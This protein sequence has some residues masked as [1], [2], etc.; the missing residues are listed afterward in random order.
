[1]M[2][3]Y[4]LLI[5]I[6]AFNCCL[7]NINNAL[8]NPPLA[9][10]SAQNPESLNKNLTCEE[11]CAISKA[12]SGT[13]RRQPG[14]YHQHNN[15]EE[16]PQ[17]LVI[18]EQI[19]RGTRQP[20]NEWLHQSSRH[21]TLANEDY[22]RQSSIIFGLT[23]IANEDYLSPACFRNLK[24]LGKAVLRKD[25]WAMK[26]LDSSGSKN[27]GFLWGQNYWLGSQDGCEA[28]Q[29]PVYITL[30]DQYERA[31]KKGLI[32]D[33]AP[34]EMDYRVVYIRHDS[35]WQVEIKFMTE[36]IIHVGL[37]LPKSCSN[38][39]VYNLT[40][41]YMDWGYFE[42]ANVY[43][44]NP[45]V[46]H[47]KDLRLRDDFFDK[48]SFKIVTVA[49][50]LTAVLM[51]LAL[52]QNSV[53]DEKKSNVERTLITTSGTE[54]RDDTKKSK[55]NEETSNKEKNGRELSISNFIRCFD[56]INNG[57]SLFTFEQASPS[58]IPVIN[59]LRSVSCLWIMLFHVIWYMYFT[60]DNK[61]FLISLGE[62]AFFQYVSTAPLLVDVFFTISGFLSVYNFIRNEKN[63]QR[64]ANSGF[65]DNCKAFGRMVLHRYLRLAPLYLIL[66]AIVE[67]FTA[68]TEDVSLFHIHERYDQTCP[69]FWWR[70]VL[71]IQ[72]L[73]SHEHLCL[74]WTW[75]LACEM[76]FYIIGIGAL[77]TY[78]KY[79][80]TIK[81]LAVL[82][83]LSSVLW[84]AFVGFE[85]HYRLSFDVMY[86]TGTQMYINPFIRIS[87]YIV[88]SIAGWFLATTKGQFSVN[89]VFEKCAWNL[90]I[91][92][93]FSCIYSTVKRDMSEL[94]TVGLYVFGRLFFSCAI[95]WVILG[96]A[97][98]RGVWWSRFLE[99]TPFQHLNKLSYGIYLLN[100]FVVSFVF[101]LSST[102]THAD[103]IMLCVQTSGFIVIVY[104]CSIIF[105]LSFEMP[106]CNIS[107]LLLR[108]KVKT[109]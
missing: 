58:S 89:T 19:F 70:N 76:Q 37:C 71:L 8:I 2:F 83:L 72:N 85:I 22:L 17:Q 64:V 107:S 44:I 33:L 46:I 62:R 12:S 97:T 78:V 55:D 5:P 30:S 56:L 103:P 32:N 3:T 57:R 9:S 41:S 50:I 36:R 61:T 59:G 4:R 45:E 75:S 109:A 7:F 11:F 66:T 47:I 67:I 105:S 77:F 6:I 94:Y 13:F 16:L 38:A 91:L 84:T 39:E 25:V 95:A 106:Y 86:H 88:G 82:G 63:L 93:F 53:C 79:P 1:M 104:I 35:P 108:R 98:G 100:P 51:F 96:S 99:L 26:V 40:Q 69:K 73:F 14:Y 42:E 92:I 20:L 28:V 31:M 10:S 43:D 29:E 80:K 24:E 23:Q 48:I 81:A 90:A 54:P 60:V 15:D 87:P 34:Y 52:W 49:V 102:S 18:K 27:A 74:N 65:V 68:Y 101:S 21:R